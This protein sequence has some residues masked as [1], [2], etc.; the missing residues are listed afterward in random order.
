MRLDVDSLVVIVNGCNKASIQYN[1][2]RVCAKST[3]HRIW[4]VSLKTFLKIKKKHLMPILLSENHSEIWNA[5]ILSR[6]LVTVL[7]RSTTYWSDG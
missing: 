3:T 2:I 4:S 1:I 6:L 7:F 5:L